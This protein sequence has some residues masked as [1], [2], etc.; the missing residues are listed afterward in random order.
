MVLV[1]DKLWIGTSNVQF[2]SDPFDMDTNGCEVWCY[3]GTTLLPIV[4]DDGGEIQSGFMNESDVRNGGARSM[5]EFPEN[6]GNIVIGTMRVHSFIWPWMEEK[7][8]QVWIR[9]A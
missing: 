2:D 6:S 7:G 1:D 9:V 4:E 8:C 5:V 3:N